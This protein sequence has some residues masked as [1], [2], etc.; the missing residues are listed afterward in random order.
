MRIV[1]VQR[2]SKALFIRQ[3]RCAFATSLRGS[4]QSGLQLLFFHAWTV[5]RLCVTG[6]NLGQRKHNEFGAC[7]HGDSRL[8]PWC[9]LGLLLSSVRLARIDFFCRLHSHVEKHL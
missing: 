3:T 4:P 5:R 2:A 7:D 1:C 8:S 6:I 9:D